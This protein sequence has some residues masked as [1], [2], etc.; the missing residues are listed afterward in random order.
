MVARWYDRKSPVMSLVVLLQS[1]LRTEW[2]HPYL[3]GKDGLSDEELFPDEDLQDSQ[4]LICPNG[5]TRFM[6]E[7]GGLSCATCGEPPVET[8]T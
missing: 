6:D 3:A 8:V 4:A 1:T 2:P 7:D 5:H